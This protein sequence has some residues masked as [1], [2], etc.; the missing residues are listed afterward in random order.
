MA[1]RATRASARRTPKPAK[2]SP[3]RPPPPYTAAAAMRRAVRARL[4]GVGP[5]GRSWHRGVRPTV[6]SLLSLR[7]LTRGAEV[8]STV[9]R[10]VIRGDD[11]RATGVAASVCVPQD[12]PRDGHQGVPLRPGFPAGLRAAPAG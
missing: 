4:M 1:R 9:I 2:P 5:P 12:A 8:R 6:L 3:A 10:T 7:V 11:A